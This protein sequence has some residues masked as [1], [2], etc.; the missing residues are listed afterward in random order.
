MSMKLVIAVV[1]DDDAG[2]LIERLVHSRFSTTKLAS[3]GGF[4]K[5]G[6]TTL[7]VGVSDEQVGEVIEIIKEMCQSRK[8]TF[9][10][11][12]PPTGSANVFIPYPIEVM[13]GG[14]TIFVLDIDQFEK[15]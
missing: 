10:A 1:Q 14:A 4:L 9:T 15:V 3:T 7:M 11:P 6:N 12:V 2:D 13:V 8:Q 5:E